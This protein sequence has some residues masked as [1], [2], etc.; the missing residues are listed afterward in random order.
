MTNNLVRNIEQQMELLLRHAEILSTLVENGSPLGILKL[1]RKTG[2]PPHQV[3]Y[4]LRELQDAEIVKATTKGAKVKEGAP[5]HLEKIE[6]DLAS[7][8]RS[9][10]EFKSRIGELP[11]RK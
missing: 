1:S 6:S 5:Q 9:L 3:R 7:V 2:Y 10:Q 11:L 4:S 8:N